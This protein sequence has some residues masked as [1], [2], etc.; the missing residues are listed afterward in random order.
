MLISNT[1]NLLELNN[2]SKYSIWGCPY[3]SASDENQNDKIAVVEN[4]FVENG[5]KP[6]LTGKQIHAIDENII[7]WNGLKPTFQMI[8][9]Y[10]RGCPYETTPFLIYQFSF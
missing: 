9:D 5:F 4:D 7:D 6:F 3:K 8:N 1:F 10:M 2:D